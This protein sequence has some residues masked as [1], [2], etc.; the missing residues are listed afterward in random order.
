MEVNGELQ[1]SA[2]FSQGKSSPVPIL[3]EAGAFIE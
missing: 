2:A 1:V 3:K